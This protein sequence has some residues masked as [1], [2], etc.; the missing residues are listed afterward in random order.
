MTKDLIVLVPDKN[1]ESAT[2]ELLQRP[3]ALGVRPIA[4][5]IFIHIGRDPGCYRKAHD[6]LRPFV[7]QYHYALVMFD[8]HGSGRE[9]VEVAELEDEVRRRLEQN[10]WPERAA[11]VV[12]E[13]ELEVWVWSDSPEVDRCLGWAGREPSL[14]EWLREQG[15]WSPGYPKP[16]DPK[17]AVEQTLRAVHKPQSSAIYAELARQVSV[18]RC[19]DPGFQ[20]FRQILGRWFHV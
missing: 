9:G 5:D 13:P 14:R 12:L 1:M 11:V 8:H 19:A 16:S 4:F 17:T 6:F 7:R 20:R 2:K 18:G 3:E 10:G 15:R